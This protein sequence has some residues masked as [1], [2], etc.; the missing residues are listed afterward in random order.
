MFCTG[1]KISLC[2]SDRE[3]LDGFRQ[4]RNAAQ[5][6]VWR[7][8]IVLLSARRGWHQRDHAAD[9]DVEDVRMA[10]AGVFLLLLLLHRS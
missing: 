8:E 5:K 4:E 6:H 1:I 2:P 9:R 7:A 3:R 10:E